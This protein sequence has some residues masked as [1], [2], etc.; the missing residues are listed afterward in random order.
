MSGALISFTLGALLCLGL[1]P[2]GASVDRGDGSAFLRGFDLDGA[3]CNGEG[4]RAELVA[5][6]DRIA[7]AP[8]VGEAQAMA[9]GQTRL[10]RKAVSRARWIVP[11]HPALGEARAK[12]DDFDARVREAKS[13]AE[14]A[15][16]FGRLVRVASA[17]DLTIVDAELKADCEYT[18]GEIVI[19]V[20]GFFLAIIPGLIFMALLC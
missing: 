7:A 9:F 19:I 13:Q 6:R 11:F 18:T 1:T 14:V 17:D 16:S 3:N 8:S 4:A 10:A 5:F 15:R 12:L 2:A 20:I